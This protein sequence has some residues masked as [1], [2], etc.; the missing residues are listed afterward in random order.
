MIITLAM[1]SR[2]L[3]PGWYCEI[4]TRVDVH[5]RIHKETEKPPTQHKIIIS[6]TLH[7]AFNKPSA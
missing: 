2:N 7:P 3:P 5:E 6:N 4:R 1:V